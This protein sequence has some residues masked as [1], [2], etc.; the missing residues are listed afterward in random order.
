MA[1]KKTDPEDILRKQFMLALHAIINRQR[2][3]GGKLTT[4]AK[5]AQHL[6]LASGTSLPRPSTTRKVQS[7]HIYVFVNEFNINAQWLYTGKGEVFMD[8][9][10][11][12]E[13]RLQEITKRLERLEGKK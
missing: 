11:T 4:V 8:E 13:Q 2:N 9:V 10:A 6:G 7:A 5:L 3:E 12:V 1:R